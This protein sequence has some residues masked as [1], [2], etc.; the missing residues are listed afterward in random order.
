[1]SAQI[2][3]TDHE[4]AKSIEACRDLFGDHPEDVISPIKS[5]A[6]AMSWL[7][8]VFRT[9]EREALNERNGY[10]IK[11]LAALGAYLALDMGEFAGGAHERMLDR[12]R[13]K[14]AAPAGGRHG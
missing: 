1:M 7:Q 11:H 12:L 13:S 9:I 2:N 10:R 8:E 5:A 4:L 6:D 14:G 3:S